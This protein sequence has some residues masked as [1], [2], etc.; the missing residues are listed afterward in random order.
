MKIELDLYNE[1]IIQLARS[2]GVTVEENSDKPGFFIRTE[3]G[4]REITVEDA[5]GL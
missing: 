1:E 4:D 2:H 5:L 3:D